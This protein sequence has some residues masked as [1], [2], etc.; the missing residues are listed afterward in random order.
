MIPLSET[1]QNCPY[2]WTALCNLGTC[3]L[4]NVQI[5]GSIS[6]PTN[7]YPFFLMKSFRTISSQCSH[8][9]RVS[10]RKYPLR[11]IWQARAWACDSSDLGRTVLREDCACAPIMLGE[12]CAFALTVLGEDCAWGGPCLGRTVLR[13]DSA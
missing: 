13:E 7:I 5:W 8:L 12:D 1:L 3:K 6:I 9:I 11:P 2:S 4:C 10:K